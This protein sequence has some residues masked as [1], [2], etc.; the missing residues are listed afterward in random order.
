MLHESPPWHPE[1]DGAGR[2]TYTGPDDPW[3][4]R[5]VLSAIE[6]LSGR[7][8]LERRYRAVRARVG[9]PAEFWREALDELRIARDYEPAALAA[10]PREGPLVVVANHP[11]GVVDGLALCELG[12]SLRTRFQILTHRALCTDRML[13][14]FLLPVDF[15]ETRDA[16]RTNIATKAEAIETLAV[17]GAVLVFPAGG[18][19][20]APGGRGKAVDLP[21]KRF[22]ARLIQSARATVVPVY[23]YGQNGRL[24][25]FVSTFSPTLRLAL[26]LREVRRH[27]GRPLRIEIGAPIPYSDLAHL[28]DRQKL[29]DHLRETT[30]ALCHR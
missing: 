24:F 20:T 17:G 5:F 1:P 21:W 10:I 29:L 3:P 25:Q 28:T 19:A 14:S 8:G 15:A 13:D 27:E 16:L 23:F 12:A 11:L 2:L 7:W 9:G 4:K 6:G 22:V 18:I 26:I 30:L